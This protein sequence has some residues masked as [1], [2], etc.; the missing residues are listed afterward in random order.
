MIYCPDGVTTWEPR[1]LPKILQDLMKP[2]PKPVPAE[3]SAAASKSLLGFLPPKIMAGN[4]SA[5]KRSVVVTFLISK[6]LLK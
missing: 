5:L 2:F 4:E 6:I 1:P 3:P